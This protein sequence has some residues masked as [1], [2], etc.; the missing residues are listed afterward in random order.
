LADIEARWRE[1]EALG[2]AEVRKQIGTY[3]DVKARLARQWLDFRSSSDSSE[4]RRKT[5]E[6]ANDAND[7]ARS[8]NDAALEANSIAR[9]AADSASLTAEAARNNNRIAAAALI[10]AIVAIALSI[11]SLIL[12][13]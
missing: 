1:F 5:L 3:G 10:A 7:L 8:A 11:T 4:I 9:K 12:R 2:E 13:R 6:V